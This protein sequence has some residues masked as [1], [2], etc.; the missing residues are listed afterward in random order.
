[1]WEEAITNIIQNARHQSGLFFFGF[2][3]DFLFLC[4]HA[5]HA[6]KKEKFFNRVVKVGPLLPLPGL[7]RVFLIRANYQR[8]YSLNRMTP[9]WASGAMCF[10][11]LETRIKLF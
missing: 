8:L 4:T 3:P 2:L 1:M 10:V 5:A 9:F 7:G 6:R 11:L